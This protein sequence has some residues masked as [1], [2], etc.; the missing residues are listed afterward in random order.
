MESKILNLKFNLILSEKNKSLGWK[1]MD[2]YKGFWLIN[3]ISVYWGFGVLGDKLDPMDFYILQGKI[4]GL[5]S[6][7]KGLDAKSC[8]RDTDVF[9]VQG[10]EITSDRLYNAI[11]LSDLEQAVEFTMQQRDE[12]YGRLTFLKDTIEQDVING[13]RIG[14]GALTVESSEG[15]M[16]AVLNDKQQAHGEILTSNQTLLKV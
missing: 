15:P 1:I 8:G 9:I 16:C 7:L 11:A 4:F 6:D 12:E 2:L 10:N 13:T 14:F 5:W 3:L